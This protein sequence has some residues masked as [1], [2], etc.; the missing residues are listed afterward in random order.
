[1]LLS[2]STTYTPATEFSYL[3]HKHPAR[4]QTF[5]LSF[6]QAHVFYPQVTAEICTAALLLDIDPIQLFRSQRISGNSSFALRQYLND[7]PYVA[8]SL[9]RL[10]IANVYGSALS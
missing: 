7:R 3:F 6:W 10:A 8:S 1:M 9:L 2:I 4:L 5:P